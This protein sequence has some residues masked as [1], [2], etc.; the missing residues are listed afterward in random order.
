MTTTGGGDVGGRGG[1]GRYGQC[2]V[3]VT[4]CMGLGVLALPIPAACVLACGGG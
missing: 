2:V 4:S 1:A 3:V